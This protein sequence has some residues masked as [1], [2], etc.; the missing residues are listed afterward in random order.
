MHPFSG[1][2][3]KTCSFKTDTENM[4]FTE[5]KGKEVPEGHK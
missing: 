2:Y 1:A 4:R 3:C 5:E